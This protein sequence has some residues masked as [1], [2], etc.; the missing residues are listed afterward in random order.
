MRDLIAAIGLLLLPCTAYAAEQDISGT[1]RLVSM[2]R[3]IVDTGQ[4][5]DTFGEH[6]AG[7]IIYQ[8]DGHFLVVITYDGLPGRLAHRPKPES[9]A[10]MTDQESADLLRTMT[11][12]GGTYAFVGNKV[13]HHIELSWN[14]FWTGTTVVR[15]VKSEGDRLIYTT[16]PALWPADDKMSFIRLVWEPVK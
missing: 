11:A 7:Y 15:D 8:K 10:K 2:V 4:V 9:F 3:V 13:E 1:Y 5:I 14:E 12:Y 16:R 6:P